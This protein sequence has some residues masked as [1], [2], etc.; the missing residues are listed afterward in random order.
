MEVQSQGTKGLEIRDSW[1]QCQGLTLGGSHL[2]YTGA[3]V[4]QSPGWWGCVG[5][6]PTSAEM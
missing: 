4:Q 5:K 3:G 6:K 1:W 2:A